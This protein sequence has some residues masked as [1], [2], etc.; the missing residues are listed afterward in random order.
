MK[1]TL[2]KNKKVL[3]IINTDADLLNEGFTY[4]II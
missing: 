1:L 3:N 2:I 4:I